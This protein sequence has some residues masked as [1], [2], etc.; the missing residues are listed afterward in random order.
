M[1]VKLTKNELRSQQIRLTQFLRYLPTL[2]LK[3]AML[4]YEV[5]LAAMEISQ[6]KE[7]DD[8]VRRQVDEFASLISGKV[9]IDFMK[10]AEISAARR[11]CLS[12]G[13]R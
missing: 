6:L 9:E 10:F 11:L 8:Q 12:L 7:E 4:Q 13:K 1:T 5:S 2:Q 3:K